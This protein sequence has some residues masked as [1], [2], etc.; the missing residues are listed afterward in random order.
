MQNRASLGINLDKGFI[1]AGESNGSDIG[2]A[3]ARLYA[4]RQPFSPPLTGL[5]L[6]CPAVMN[7]DTVPE[8]YKNYFLS[9][10]QNA[11]APVLPADS[12]KFIQC[13]CALF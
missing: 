8:K 12:I 9:M 13:R 10:D 3:V 7:K 6:A 11:N 5:Y 1:I 2:L 4:D